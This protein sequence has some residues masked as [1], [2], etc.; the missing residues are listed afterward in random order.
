MAGAAAAAAMTAA[1]VRMRKS[2]KVLSC[3]DRDES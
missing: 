3:F 2:F 1:A